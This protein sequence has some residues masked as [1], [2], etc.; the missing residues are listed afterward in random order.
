MRFRMQ[1][2]RNNQ[3]VRLCGFL[4]HSVTRLL[5]PQI[6]HYYGVIRH[7]TPLRIVLESPLEN[8]PTA[9]LASADNVR[10]PQLLC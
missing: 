10:L 9:E 2:V 4:L 8:D 5:R 1:S 3:V 6:T 7:L